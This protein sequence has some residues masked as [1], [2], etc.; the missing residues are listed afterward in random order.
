MSKV[1]EIFGLKRTNGT[2]GIE[3][4]AEGARLRISDDDTK[5]WSSHDDGSL[6]G[7]FP[8]SRHEY[9]TR[10]AI[11]YGEVSD[12]IDELIELNKGATWDFSFRT[13]VH[14]HLNAQEY[15]ERQLQNVIYT[16]LLVEELMINYCG[17][18]RKCNRF[19]LRVQDADG[20]FLA[21]NNLYSGGLKSFIVFLNDNLRYC[22]LNLNCL[23]KYG[24]IEFRGMR[25]T[26][27]KKVLT[28]WITAI[29]NIE[30]Y[31]LSKADITEIHDDYAE[32]QYEEFVQKVLGDVYKDF[33]YEGYE[34]DMAQS[35]SLTIELPHLFQVYNEKEKLAKLK[36]KAELNFNMPPPEM[37]RPDQVVFIDDLAEGDRN[38]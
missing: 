14:V 26:I 35:F 9:V 15:T 20:I 1:L 38:V 19:C 18:E 4:E 2:F 8:G 33:L 24:S 3:I 29:A 34:H 22:S 21:L 11:K 37:I 30:K 32:S 17:E 6:R 10:G 23:R 25:G 5:F 13:S 27:D 28:T 36:R 31:A 12:A 7:A 16:Y